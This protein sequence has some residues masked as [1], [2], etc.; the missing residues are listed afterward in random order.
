MKKKYLQLIAIAITSISSCET[1]NMLNEDS[2]KESKDLYV[3]T[4][5][6]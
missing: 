3:S 6:G 2:L 4:I 5:D 1:E